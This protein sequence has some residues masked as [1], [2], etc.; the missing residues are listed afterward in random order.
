M[1]PTRLAQHGL[2]LAWGVAA[3]T[4]GAATDKPA[5][6][7]PVASPATQPTHAEAANASPRKPPRI[8]PTPRITA[9]RT[10]PRAFPAEQLGLG[11]ASAK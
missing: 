7:S 11:C 8:A 3:A 5:V 2:W 9:A 4:A 6:D 1:R 10:N